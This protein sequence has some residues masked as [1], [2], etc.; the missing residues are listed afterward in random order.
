MSYR[1]KK[2]PIRVRQIKKK[3][4][5]WTSEIWIYIPTTGVS[6]NLEV[7]TIYTEANRFDNSFQQ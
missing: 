5:V 3:P 7:K 6:E 4:F 1:E 2:T